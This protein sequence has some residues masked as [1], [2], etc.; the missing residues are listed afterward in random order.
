M[1]AQIHHLTEP[2]TDNEIYD[3]LKAV[4]AE[5][6]WSVARMDRVLPFQK[7]LDGEDV[8]EWLIVVN[9]EG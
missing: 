3:F 1:K 6:H 4:M 7:N 2:M 9:K 5:K 8:T